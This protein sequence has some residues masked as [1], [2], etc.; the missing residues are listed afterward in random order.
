VITHVVLC[1][2]VNRI[3]LDLCIENMCGITL[4]TAAQAVIYD[5]HLLR[6]RRHKERTARVG[7]V[8]KEEGKR[9][10]SAAEQLVEGPVIL[11]G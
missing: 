7:D 3:G 1:F 6:E 10:V 5:H 9:M 4:S 11:N 8:A 2:V